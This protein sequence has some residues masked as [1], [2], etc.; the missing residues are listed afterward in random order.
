MPTNEQA[1]TH[2]LHFDTCGNFQNTTTTAGRVKMFVR[3]IVILVR[4]EKHEE[5]VAK[6]KVTLMHI[7]HSAGNHPRMS[8]KQSPW[9]YK[10][11][12]NEG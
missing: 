9:I 4:K 2:T 3:L 8:T 11:S 6:K 5:S 10:A 7:L 1:E 12:E